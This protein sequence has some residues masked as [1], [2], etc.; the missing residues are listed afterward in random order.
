MSKQFTFNSELGDLTLTL[1]ELENLHRIAITTDGRVVYIAQDSNG[2]VWTFNKRPSRIDDCGKFV[3]AGACGESARFIRKINDGDVTK[4]CWAVTAEFLGQIISQLKNGIVEKRD[5]KF[6]PS[7]EAT[8]NSLTVNLSEEP[9]VLDNTQ[10]MLL[11]AFATA[12]LSKDKPLYIT[13]DYN[14]DIWA[15]NESPVPVDTTEMGQGNYWCITS[16]Y[17]SAARCIQ[18]SVGNQKLEN[19]RD[20]IVKVAHKDIVPMADSEWHYVEDVDFPKDLERVIGW[21]DERG[22]HVDCFHMCGVWRNYHNDKQILNIVAW[23]PTLKRPA[24]FG[25]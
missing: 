23:R 17:S 5:T 4:E 25:D 11:K 15:F 18:S 13:Q 21:D 3:W 16:P 8:R 19:W 6:S 24:R 10:L 9:F 1:E 12:K 14:G 7:Y 2:S 20:R 22:E